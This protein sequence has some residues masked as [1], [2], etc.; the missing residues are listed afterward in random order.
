MEPIE[1]LVLGVGLVL[2]GLFGAKGKGV[3]KTAAKGCMAAGEKAQEW[4]SNIRGDLRGA[5][6]QARTEREQ[7]E[8][9]RRN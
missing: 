9:A 2:G 3:V 4:T 5:V 7:E 1:W 6:E 8:A